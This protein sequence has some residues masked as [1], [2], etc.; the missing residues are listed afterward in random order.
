MACLH[1]DNNNNELTNNQHRQSH[2]GHKDTRKYIPHDDSDN[3]NRIRRSDTNSPDCIPGTTWKQDCNSCWCTETG[4]AACTLMG[5]LHLPPFNNNN[6][7]GFDPI[8]RIRRKRSSSGTTTNRTRFQNSLP[9]NERNCKHGTTWMKSCNR[10][11]CFGGRAACTRMMCL[12]K[13]D[14][15]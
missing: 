10:C 1:L 11:R 13:E 7:K 6:A 8:I 5:C 3:H 15:L 9:E 12:E 4:I 2:F 14:N